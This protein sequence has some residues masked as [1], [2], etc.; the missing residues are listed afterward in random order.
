MTIRVWNPLG[1]SLVQDPK[2][3]AMSGHTGAITCFLSLGYHLI[4]ASTD[5]SII[6]WNGAKIFAK[7]D[8]PS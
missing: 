2:L 7:K 8:F 5:K 6:V 1:G 4:S 3:H